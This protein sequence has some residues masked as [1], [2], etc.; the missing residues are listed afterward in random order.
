MFKNAI[1][2]PIYT[3]IPSLLRA[4][5][6]GNQS[7]APVHIGQFAGSLLPRSDRDHR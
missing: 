7:S 1:L 2:W 5:T 3:L 6:R 4:F